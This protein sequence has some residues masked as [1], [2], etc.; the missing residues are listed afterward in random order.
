M[1]NATEAD[2]APYCLGDDILAIIISFLQPLDMLKILSVNKQWRLA[3]NSAATR[4]IE[5]DKL[6]RLPKV[7]V[8]TLFLFIAR[9]M[10]VH[11]I[12]FDLILLLV[13]AS[14][15]LITHVIL[16]LQTQLA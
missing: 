15:L 10:W 1:I 9:F 13:K 6:S 5:D 8:L 3:A 11:Q 7:V 14:L 2:L 16:W 12:L 4:L